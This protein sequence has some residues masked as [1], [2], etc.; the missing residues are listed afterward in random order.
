MFTT[1]FHPERT[2]DEFLK[3]FDDMDTEIA[4]PRVNTPT[5]KAARPERKRR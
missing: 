2:R 5:R 1:A 3:T 4:P